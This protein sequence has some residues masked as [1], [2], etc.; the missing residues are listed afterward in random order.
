MKRV[1]LSAT[2]EDQMDLIE[3]IKSKLAELEIKVIHFKE[4]DFFNGKTGV[5]SHDICIEK[6]RETPNYLLIVN[7][8]AG[9]DYEGS[10]SDYHG[11]SLTHA[12]FRSALESTSK[13]R[14]MYCFVRRKVMEFFEIWKHLPNK[15]NIDSSWTV[16]PKVLQLLEDM[17]TKGIWID[18]FQH[19]LE[20]KKFLSV[21]E[22]V[23]D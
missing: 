12:E 5:H 2:Y 19:S 10:I 13:N 3:E 21:K 11:L 22:F 16:E 7:Y 14:K 1:F 23:R 4:P 20:L 18:F 8:R 6:V 9:I 15:H 17:E